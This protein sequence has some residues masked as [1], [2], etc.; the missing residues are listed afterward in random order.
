MSDDEI[1]KMGLGGDLIEDGEKIVSIASFFDRIL[2][3]EDLNIDTSIQ[4]FIEYLN[5]LL[6]LRNP[7]A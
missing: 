3:F 6:R 5:I 2:S 4:K 1:K 7:F